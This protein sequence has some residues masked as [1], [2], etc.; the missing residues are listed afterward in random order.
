MTIL[1]AMK[2]CMQHPGKTAARYEDYEPLGSIMFRDGQWFE[3][4]IDGA[5]GMAWH[6]YGPLFTPEELVDDDG[7]PREYVT[8]LVSQIE[9]TR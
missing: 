3:W 2:V 6:P 4:N 1:D 7:E 8:F 5:G 9:A